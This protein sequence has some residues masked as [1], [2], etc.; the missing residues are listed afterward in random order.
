MKITIC[1]VCYKNDKKM[2]KSTYRIGWKNG[3][4]IDV[5]DN[6]KDFCKGKKQSDVANWYY[7]FDLNKIEIADVELAEIPK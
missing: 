7:N 4:R 2:E 6:H 3:L 5:C 1:D